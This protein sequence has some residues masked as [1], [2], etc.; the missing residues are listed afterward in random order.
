MKYYNAYIQHKISKQVL[1]LNN[2]TLPNELSQS[3]KKLSDTISNT[4]SV[5]DVKNEI[6]MLNELWGCQF[7][8]LTFAPSPLDT[9][10][11]FRITYKDHLYIS[12]KSK[13]FRILHMIVYDIS[14]SAT[15]VEKSHL[16]VR[17]LKQMN[18]WWRE[19]HAR[20]LG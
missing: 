16:T 4:K 20:I 18:D 12:Q 5:F 9:P 1:I 3:I 7:A 19:L 15:Q 17:N 10:I 6:V 8:I 13:T 14:I 2:S 11:Y